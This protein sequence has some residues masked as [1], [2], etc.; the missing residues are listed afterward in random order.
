[1]EAYD[2]ARRSRLSGGGRWREMGRRWLVK[3]SA[4][5]AARSD[6][7]RGRAFE[8]NVPSAVAGLPF[9]TICTSGCGRQSRTPS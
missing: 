3:P 2:T 4:G 8:R 7:A 1:M 5:T 6:G 9:R